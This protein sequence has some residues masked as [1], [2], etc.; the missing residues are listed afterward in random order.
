MT[1]AFATSSLRAQNP[2]RGQFMIA[3]IAGRQSRR[4][5]KAF[6]TVEFTGLVSLFIGYRWAGRTRG[7]SCVGCAR[8]VLCARPAAIEVV[9]LAIR[10]RLMTQAVIDSFTP[11]RVSGVGDARAANRRRRAPGAGE[12]I[13]GQVAASSSEPRDA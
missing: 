6:T 7:K 12:V 8:S 5:S 13:R 3:V 9:L 11:E 4:L 10:Q 1:N 2:L